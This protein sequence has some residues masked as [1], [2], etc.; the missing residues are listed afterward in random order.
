MG[1]SDPAARGALNQAA[2]RRLEDA[3]QLGLVIARQQGVVAWWHHTQALF[4][5]VGAGRFLP[6][7]AGLSDYVGQLRGGLALA[8]E[9]KSTEDGRLYRS[10]ITEAQ[11]QHL[12]ACAAGAGL[13]VL[14]V[15]FRDTPGWPLYLVPWAEVPWVRKR[16]A[17]SLTAAGL[18]VAGWRAST[19]DL[20][21][22]LLVV[23]QRCRRF[24][25]RGRDGGG[26]WCGG[27]LA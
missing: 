25:P 21:G 2:G 14:A 8:I 20:L 19:Q 24:E 4:R 9:A 26:A 10:A 15:Q 1:A 12:A 5:P 27:A 13:A 7:A 18:E 3:I 23:C 17:D 16:T 22:P 11:Q 6:V